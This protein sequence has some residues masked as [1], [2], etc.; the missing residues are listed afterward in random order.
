MWKYGSVSDFCFTQPHKND[1]KGSTMWTCEGLPW[2]T[3]TSGKNNCTCKTCHRQLA[4]YFRPPSVCWVSLH[5]KETYT[6]AECS[7]IPSLSLSLML[8][9]SV[10]LPAHSYLMVFV[11][12]AVG[13]VQSSALSRTQNS[14]F[15]SA[16]SSVPTLRSCASSLV[17]PY[18]TLHLRV[19]Y[20][21]VSL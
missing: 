4:C 19:F 20:C 8:K 13:S 9:R 1:I 15:R 5:N 21:I 12:L 6:Y 2:G 16:V 17:A 3:F 11:V 10:D 7:H 18:Q 14:R